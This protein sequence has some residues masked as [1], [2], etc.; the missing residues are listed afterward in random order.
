MTSHPVLRA[1]ALGALTAVLRDEPAAALPDAAGPWT[2]FFELASAHG[3]LPAVWVAL[4]DAG[5][6]SLS[7]A[8]AATLEQTAPPGRAVPEVVIR[9]AYDRNV[10]RAAMLLDAGVDILQR[11]AS[12]GIRSVP[13]KGLHSVLAG[14]WPDPAARTM[15]DLDV[16]VDAVEAARAYASLRAA[17]Y[18]E[19][20]DPIGEHADHHLPM[21]GRGEVTVEL[22]TE[23]LVSRWQPL[24]PADHVLGRAVRAST[25]RGTLLLADATDAFVHLVAH[26]QLQDETYTRLGLPL[27]ALHE[28]A[29]LDLAAIDGNDLH[30]RFERAGVGHVLAAHLDAARHLFGAAAPAVQARSRLA[31]QA[32]SRLAVQARSRRAVIHTRLVEAGVALPEVVNGWTYAVRLPRSFTEDRMVDE[33]GPADGPAWVWRARARHVA[34]RAALRLGRREGTRTH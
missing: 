24:A 10:G 26:A 5:R 28:T 22:H 3:L 6:V 9:R 30:E 18:D 21:L 14:T 13:L 33:F 2:A 8:V 16:L 12:E 15:A 19:H 20:P 7:S 23:L 17:G 25:S 29:R 11:F 4:R 1:R 32:G 31:V 34:R 27:R